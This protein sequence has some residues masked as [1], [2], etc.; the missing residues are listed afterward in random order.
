MKQC[1]LALRRLGGEGAA[2]APAQVR[3]SLL[4]NR[5]PEGMEGGEGALEKPD[6]VGFL[7]PRCSVVGGKDARGHRLE[8]GPLSWCETG[9]S[10]RLGFTG[11]AFA[12]RENQSAKRAGLEEAAAVDGGHA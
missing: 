1:V 4:D 8:V 11:R 10:G 12:P 7:R 3:E 9:R 2:G 6:H 5:K